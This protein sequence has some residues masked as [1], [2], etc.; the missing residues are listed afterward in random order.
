MFKFDSWK[1]FTTKREFYLNYVD[2][3]KLASDRRKRYIESLMKS[4]LREVALYVAYLV[5]VYFNAYTTITP[6][7]FKY[8]NSLKNIFINPTYSISF[9]EV[10]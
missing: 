7:N 6:N 10:R 5:V 9:E 4:K 3:E 8:G 2:E 1:E